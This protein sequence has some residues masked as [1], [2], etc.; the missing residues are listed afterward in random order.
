[1]R[2]GY[3]ED[4]LSENPAY[5]PGIDVDC[6]VCHARLSPP[7][8]TISVMAEGDDRSYFYRTHKPCFEGLSEQQ[9]SDLDGLIIDR[10]HIIRN[11]S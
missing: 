3:F 6:P 9:A 7:L 10:F 4:S 8:K 1:M 11:L 5:D 2:F